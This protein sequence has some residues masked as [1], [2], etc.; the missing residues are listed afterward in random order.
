M[1]AKDKSS[2]KGNP[3][4][5][6]VPRAGNAGGKPESYRTLYV[7]EST[8]QTNFPRWRE[9]VIK[10]AKATLFFH[11]AK[12]LEK[13]KKVLYPRP[14]LSDYMTVPE[15]TT[16]RPSARSQSS[17]VGSRQRY[18][19]CLEKEGWKKAYSAEEETSFKLLKHDD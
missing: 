4:K 9:E 2:K 19:R 8:G 6:E 15:K 7:N 17:D 10:E 11:T 3:R 12:S 16:S 1:F 13:D 14:K 5:A 18:Q